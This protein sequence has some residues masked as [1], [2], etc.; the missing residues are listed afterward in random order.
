[1]PGAAADAH[2]VSVPLPLSC[3]DGEPRTAAASPH[4]TA[5]EEGMWSPRTAAAVAGFA[6]CNSVMLVCNKVAIHLL[7]VPSL[8]LAAQLAVS[9]LF[10]VVGVRAGA[11]EADAFERAKVTAFFP[12]VLAF[13]AA[14]F[15]NA[16][17]RTCAREMGFCRVCASAQSALLSALLRRPLA[18][19]PPQVLEHANVETF[20]VVRASSPLLVAL[21][22]WHFLGRELPDGRGAA[23]LLTI[24]AGALAYVRTDATLTLGAGVWSAAWLCVFVF[25][26][27]YIK[28]G[29]R[30]LCVLTLRRAT[31]E[32]AASTPPVCDTV[33]M[34]AWGRVLYS[35]ALGVVPAIL[36]GAIFREYGALAHYVWTRHA[37][38]ALALSCA[39]GVGMSYSSFL[40]RVQVS[41]TTFTVIGILC[42]V[43]TVLINCLV[44]DKHASPGGLAALAVCLGAGV[45]YTPAPLRKT[46]VERKA[47]ALVEG[48]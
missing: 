48:C 45:L 30:P 16:K 28:H 27:I 18:Y 36:L 31:D 10:V 46:A 39:V 33:P 20:V 15:C 21:C 13:L 3:K 5:R 25:D 35:N 12:V 7:P 40:L 2:A 41:A 1:M 26:Q 11:L 23:V 9:A 34:S 22:D 38:G 19:A 6:L 42:K 14:I 44:W 37:L 24:L 29:E 47:A 8:V 17:A 43:F 32:R 4:P